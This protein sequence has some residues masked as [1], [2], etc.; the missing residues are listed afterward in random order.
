MHFSLWKQIHHCATLILDKSKS[1]RRRSSNRDGGGSSDTSLNAA[2]KESALLRKLYEDKLR[3]ALEEASENGS[4]FKSQTI[5]QG[6]GADA[7]AVGRSR[8]LARLHAQRDFLRATALAAEHVF[9]SEDSLPDLLEALTKFLTMYPK[10]QASEKIDQ[11]RSDEYNHLSGSKVCL[12]YC[13]F[14]LFSYVQTLHYW[15]TCTFSLSEITANLSNHALYGGAE[16]GT[17]EH[18]IKTRIMDYL[19]IPE[20]EYGLVFTVSRGSAFKLLAESYPFQ[21]NKRLLT[22]FDHES[23]SVNWMAQTAKEKGAKAYNAWFKWPSLKLCSTDLKKRLSYKKRKKK[24]SA[25]GLF[26]FPAQSRVTG[27]KYSYQ[28]MALAQQNHWHVLLDAGSLGPK[29]MDSLGL[30][31]FRPEFIV[32]SFYRVFGH[33]PTGF[34]CLLIKKSV[35]GSLQSQSGKTGSGIVKITPQYP[36]YLSDSVDGL[37][38]L[39]GF[40]DDGKTKEASAAAAH[41]RPAFSGAYTSAQVRDVFE[42]DILEDNISSDRDGTTSTTIFEEETESVSVGELMKSPVFSEDE[43]SENSFWID[44][45]QSP[46]GGSNKIASPLP[47]VWFSKQKQRHSGTKQGPKSYSN[48]IYDDG[49]DV[50]SFDAAVM[51]VTEHTTPTRNNRRSSGSNNQ[52]IQEENC[53]SEIKESAIRRETE[54]E[55]RLLGGRDGGRSRVLGVEDEHTSKGR[56]VSFNVDRVS[57]SIVEPGEPSLSSVYDEEYNHNASDDDEGADDEWDRRESETE[58]VCR[59]IDH[60]NMLGLNRTTTR[61]RFLINWLVVS[62]LQLQVAESGGGRKMSLVQIY[63]PKI[64]YERGAAVAFNVRD[65]GKGFVSPEIVQRLG[66]REGISLGIGILSHIRV[67]DD[68]N[69]PRNHRGAPRSSSSSSSRED[70]GL[71]LPSEVGRNGFMRFEVVT[72]SLSFLTNFEDVYKL[73]GFVAKFLNPG[74]SREGSLPTVEEEE[75]EEDSET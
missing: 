20:N 15:D 6:D 23:Q 54:G 38:G 56:R 28:W 14:G 73:W 50:L 43:S 61:L 63:G 69:K 5:D 4:L 36:L 45:G 34:G 30:S 24:D 72:A 41:R 25:V 66:E 12:D 37:D 1:S 44:L 65:R 33:D 52:E 64:K 60:V 40:E 46:L 19:N 18:D 71:N 13:G 47:P 70:G 7:A 75:A 62:L 21:T 11:L 49:R 55:F 39:V 74:F 8:S 68:N 51:S 42:T 35:M 9:E 26:V 32:T 17:V 29:D 3:E 59:H 48:P 22:M 27:G 57:H 67:V 16:S 58:I 10:Y 31:L 53:S 2:R